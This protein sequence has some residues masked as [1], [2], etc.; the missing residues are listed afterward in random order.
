MNEVLSEAEMYELIDVKNEIA[1][2][3]CQI[4]GFPKLASQRTTMLA[5][6]SNTQEE[7]LIVNI[8][9]ENQLQNYEG[10]SGAPVIA[11][12]NIV[13]IITKQK[14]SER[15][16]ALPIKY[17][18]TVLK[19]EEISIKNKEIPINI[20]EE[21]FNLRSLTEKVEQVISMVG[22]RYS[23][24]LNVKTGTYNNLSFMLKKD[25][26]AERLQD[27]S[28][29]IRD[30]TKKLIKFD[31]YNQDEGDLV[32]AESRKGITDIVEQLQTDSIVLDSDSY[33]ESELTQVLKNIKECKQNLI[34]IFEVEKKRFE[35]KN[36]AGTYNNK[37]WRGFMASYMCTFPAQYLDEL[38]DVISTLPLIAR[39]FDISLM[40]NAG[41]RAI[42]VT[43]K[44]GIGK[45][46]LLCDIVRDFVDKGIPA[47]L[48]LGDMFKGKDTV[49]NVIINWFQKGETIE[50]F[51]AWLNEYGNQN[52]VY[53]D[54]KSVV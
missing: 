39:L 2:V 8:K 6:I 33:D 35:K 50:N 36:G 45:T 41:N 37:S 44:G 16:E 34:K 9:K 42:L 53:V 28:S 12:G 7:Q 31:S 22:P 54:R 26:I 23:K 3:G 21:T 11:L 14:D 52:N 25:G 49:D 24:E 5:T 27:I 30:C 47:V 40:N 29:Q 19:C 1:G 38:W 18:N 13:G 48:L 20:S 32:L 51:F 46:H 17:I 15:L 4:I 10:V 43:G